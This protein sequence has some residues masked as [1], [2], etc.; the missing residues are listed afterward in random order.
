MKRI[1]FTEDQIIGVLRKTEAGAKKADLACMHSV[2]EA[3]LYNWNAKCGGLEPS[4]AKRLRALDDENA[5]HDY[6]LSLPTR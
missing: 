5:S 6:A 1:R 2:S 4:E 3:A